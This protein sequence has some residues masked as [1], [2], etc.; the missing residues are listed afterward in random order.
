MASVSNDPSTFKGP[1][2]PLRHRCPQ[3]T[4]TGPQLLRCGACRAVRYCS[5][6]HQ[7]AHRPQHKSACNK[8]KKARA[9]LLEEDGLVRNATE[10]FMTP[11]NA[12][13]THVGR[14]WGLL[15]TRDYMRARFALAD[16]LCSLGTLDGVQEALQ[17]MQD[18]LRLCRSDNMGLR[19]MVPA[20]MLRLDLD[21]ECYDFVKW[22][23]TCDPDGRYDWGDM[24]LPHLNIH[25]ADVLE[26]VD[27]FG[28]Y[29]ALCH[30]VAILLLKLKLLVDIRNL[31]MTRKILASRHLPHDLWQAIELSVIRSPLSLKLQKESP[32]SLLKTERK[33]LDQTRQLGAAVVEANHSFMFSLFDPDE[34]LCAEPAP[35][36]MGSW[37]EMALAMQRSYASWWEMEGV[38]DLLND[39]RACAARDSEDEIDDMMEGE[40]RRLGS[41]TAEE[42][43]SDVSVNRIW[44]YLDWAVENASYLGPWSD[45]P[46]EQHTRENKET[47]AQAMAEEAEFDE[48]TESDQED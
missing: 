31:K 8:I 5:R 43:L 22:W 2:G 40:A 37:E 6:E 19:D 24:S 14:F 32:E 25:G 41:R 27:F 42:M 46:S 4:A 10:D 23:A 13:E 26:N 47:W 44:G 34:A 20:L 1:V 17:H 18:M 45:R 38:L 39:A 7:A 11:A 3:C 12:F 28:K 16:R 35:Y 36:S 15:S 21:Q 29:P 30:I 33:L 9:K 48:W